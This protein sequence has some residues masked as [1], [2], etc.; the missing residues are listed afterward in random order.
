MKLRSSGKSFLG[1]MWTVHKSLNSFIFS[2]PEKC[3]SPLIP[4]SVVLFCPHA[5]SWGKKVLYM[6]LVLTD[7]HYL[8]SDPFISFLLFMIALHL[9]TSLLKEHLEYKSWPGASFCLH[10]RR[11]MGMVRRLQSHHG[12]H[13]DLCTTDV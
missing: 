1:G 5:Y 7:S 13:E 6:Y 9:N 12:T 4:S 11:Y 10:N 3:W 8:I 2:L